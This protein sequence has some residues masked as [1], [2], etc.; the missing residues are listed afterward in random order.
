MPLKVNIY[1][2]KTIGYWL[3]LSLC[4][5]KDLF[6]K[7]CFFK[8]LNYSNIAKVLAKFSNLVVKIY[9]HSVVNYEYELCMG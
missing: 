3:Y 7:H 6:F 1:N 5:E 8:S 2:I 9:F 4:R